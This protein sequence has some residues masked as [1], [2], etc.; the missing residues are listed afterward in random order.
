MYDI[1]L[2]FYVFDISYVLHHL[3][4]VE[5]P[6]FCLNCFVFNLEIF[7]YVQPVIISTPFMVIWG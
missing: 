1:D 3:E 4:I 5:I 2:D 6:Y 7:H